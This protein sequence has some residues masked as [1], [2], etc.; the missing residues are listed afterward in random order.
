MSAARVKNNIALSRSAEIARLSRFTGCDGFFFNSVI[1]AI[2]ISYLI[3]ILP[4]G[5]NVKNYFSGGRSSF[6]RDFMRR[7]AGAAKD[8]RSPILLSMKSST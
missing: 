3:F 1:F 7:Y 5:A 8:E 4:F 6:L 2:V